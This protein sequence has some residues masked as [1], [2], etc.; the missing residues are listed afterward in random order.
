MTGTFSYNHTMK[1]CQKYIAKLSNTRKKCWLF[2]PVQWCTCSQGHES[3]HD[4]IYKLKQETRKGKPQNPAGKHRRYKCAVPTC[5]CTCRSCSGQASISKLL[6]NWK[7]WRLV[8]LAKRP[9]QHFGKF[10]NFVSHNA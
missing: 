10:H 2:L 6:Y 7:I 5:T 3:L 1:F 4:K 9:C 8:N